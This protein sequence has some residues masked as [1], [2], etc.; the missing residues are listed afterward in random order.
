MT[1]PPAAAPILQMEPSF[2]EE[3]ARAVCAYMQSGAWITEYQYTQE[4]E[5]RLAAFLGAPHCIAN[6]NGTTS[7]ALALL[8]VGVRAGDKVVVPGYTMIASATAV[9]LIGAKPVF[10][11]VERET[12]C[13]DA[14]QVQAALSD[15]VK[16]VIS[17]DIN[18]RCGDIDY[19]RE[20]CRSRGIYVIEDASQALGSM[21]RGRFCGTLGDIATFSL[22]SQKIIST[23]QGGVVVTA[24]AELADRVRKLKDFGRRRGGV[25]RH[26]T[27]GFNFKFTDLQAVIGIEQLK[28]LPDRIRHRKAAHQ[29]YQ[30]LLSDTP[31]IE[32]LPTPLENVTPWMTDI[33]VDCAD[34]LKAHLAS[35]GI[36]SRRVHPAIHGELAYYDGKVNLPV[37]EDAARRG[38]WLPSASTLTKSD[39]DRVCGIIAEFIGR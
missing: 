12:L 16:A 36:G 31:G 14:D 21:H 27:I 10:V 22:S 34:E 30:S 8:A 7:L 23:G 32:M 11:D 13:L 37:S 19:L 17:V 25:D 24:D 2:G 5:Q 3:E 20:L 29:H 33:Y 15:E 6:T 26:D 38:L 28:K 35:R 9:S 4:F 18:G 1:P 39:V